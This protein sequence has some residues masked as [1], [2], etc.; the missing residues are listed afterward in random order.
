MIDLGH[1]TGWLKGNDPYY[2][3]FFI[4]SQFVLTKK[5]K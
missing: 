4:A 5:Q 2:E 3:A 1:S